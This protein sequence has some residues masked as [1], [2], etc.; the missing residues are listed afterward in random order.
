MNG[1]EKERMF[2]VTSLFSERC[3][4]DAETNATDG[5][6]VTVVRECSTEHA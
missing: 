2:A 5:K 4:F 6:F 1:R 3:W